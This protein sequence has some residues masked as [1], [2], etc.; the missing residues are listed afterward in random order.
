MMMIDP[1]FMKLKLEP[2]LDLDSVELKAG[3]EKFLDEVGIYFFI[4]RIER[5]LNPTPVEKHLGITPGVIQQIEAGRFNWSV[6]ML[7]DIWNHYYSL[8]IRHDLLSRFNAKNKKSLLAQL[9][10]M[11]LRRNK[12]LQ[13]KEPIKLML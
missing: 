2:E 12:F 9:I 5:N 7:E 11:G 10:K 8:P 6:N 13:E 1:S 4:L 3:Y